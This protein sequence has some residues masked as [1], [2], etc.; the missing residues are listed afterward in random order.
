MAGAPYT[1][2]YPKTFYTVTG[3]HK[4]YVVCSKRFQLVKWNI[5]LDKRQIEREQRVKSFTWKIRGKGNFFPKKKKRKKEK[6]HSHSFCNQNDAVCELCHT[7]QHKMDLCPFSKS[8]HEA[9]KR[10][11][12]SALQQ[13]VCCKWV[14]C[15][16]Q[17]W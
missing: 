12:F 2:G 13:S 15:P 6:R 9:R 5:Y 14:F 3:R 8:I 7:F 1:H 16:Q 11:T 17:H 10:V 4:L